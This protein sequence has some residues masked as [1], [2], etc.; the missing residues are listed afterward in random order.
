MKK[1]LYMILIFIFP[2]FLSGK[3][4]F[5]QLENVG[6]R[7][8]VTYEDGKYYYTYFVTNEN[9]EVDRGIGVVESLWL[10]L[11]LPSNA[12]PLPSTGLDHGPWWRGEEGGGKPKIVFGKMKLPFSVTFETDVWHGKRLC[13]PINQRLG[14]ERWACWRP[15]WDVDYN[16]YLT[17]NG[18]YWGYP[19]GESYTSSYFRDG[20]IE[21]MPGDYL[22]FT[23]ITYGIP[24]VRIIKFDS[25]VF[26]DEL[27]GTIEER[28]EFYQTTGLDPF[29]VDD[30]KEYKTYTI[31]PTSPT[32]DF[33]FTGFV[34]K[35]EENFSR[36]Q[37]YGWVRCSGGGGY[38]SPPA[39]GVRPMG[40]GG[41][42]GGG[43]EDYCGE[44]ITYLENTISL[45]EQGDI[46][47]AKNEIINAMNF[48]SSNGCEDYHEACDEEGVFRSE[49]YGLFYYDLDFLLR[50]LDSGE[51]LGD[52]FRVMRAGVRRKAH[53]KKVK[54]GIQH[55]R[56]VSSSE[57][58]GGHQGFW[59]WLLDLIKA[60]LRWLGLVR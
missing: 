4:Y 14:Y 39:G 7:A 60:I 58:G 49:A 8:K 26:V 16:G 40:M 27:F 30:I 15:D 31:G 48:I 42:G 5:F 51:D 32:R 2:A 43:S 12:Y 18:T 23:V 53:Q 11:T 6:V 13:D 44:F 57:E 1:F 9:T 24:A 35:M 47:G 21:L 45:Y 19:L 59:D 55:K 36:A 46:E 20:N 38:H 28:E 50:Y 3:E 37:E 41:G 34:G 22:E 52:V 54:M 33:S 29:K 17:I 25:D 56:K 10:D